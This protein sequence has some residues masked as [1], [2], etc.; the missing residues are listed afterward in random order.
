MAKRNRKAGEH[1]TA[2]AVVVWCFD[3]GFT[4]ALD[5]L[6]EKL[7]LRVIDLV[8]V[9]G[10]AKNLL[11]TADKSDR[12]FVLGQIDDSNRLHHTK[13]VILMTHSDCGAFGGL[14]AFGDDARKE[15][16]SHMALL[17]QARGVV[18]NY[19]SKVQGLSVEIYFCDFKD[20]HKVD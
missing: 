9:A 17:S 12:D 2:D 15:K 5:E 1:Y 6:K 10:G 18:A 11:P 16:E 20:C 4:P 13:R 19:F 3:Y 8:S 14:S 7:G